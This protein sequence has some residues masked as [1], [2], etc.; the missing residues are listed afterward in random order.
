MDAAKGNLV[1]KRAR[2]R[3]KYCGL[4]RSNSRFVPFHIEHKRA[5]PHDGTDDPSN[6]A[7]S[8]Q[9]CN[10]H[11]GPHLTGIDPETNEIA[12]LFNPREDV[13][14]EHF[15]VRGAV[16]VGLTPIGSRGA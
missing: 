6:L 16:I 15:V 8:C 7:F 1:R 2:N 3:C 9:N 5:R 4:K 10:L 14:S 12:R 11:K 13:R